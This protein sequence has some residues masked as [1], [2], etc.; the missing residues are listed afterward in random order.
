MIQGELN[1]RKVTKLKC[2]LRVRNTMGQ[3]KRFCKM[4]NKG[5]VARILN[6]ASS[7]YQNGTNEKSDKDSIR[8]CS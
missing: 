4:A 3:K 5:F 2:T 7:L 1:G 8:H 6:P